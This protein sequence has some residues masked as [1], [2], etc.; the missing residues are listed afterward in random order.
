MSKA[1]PD[2]PGLPHDGD[3]PVFSAPWQAQAFALAVSLN[4]AGHFAWTEWTNCFAPILEEEQAAPG[5]ETADVNETYYKA[6]L[7]ALE[8]LVVEKGIMTAPAL[9]QRKDAWDRAA[10]ATP[11]GEPIVLGRVREDR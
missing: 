10:R 3:E 5:A 1:L 11:H 7:K 9:F 6:W 8:T 2:I 4:E